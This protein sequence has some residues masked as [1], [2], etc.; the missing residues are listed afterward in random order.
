MD[1]RMFSK[2]TNEHISNV[3]NILKHFSRQLI[4]R[5]VEHDTSKFSDT[6]AELFVEYTPKLKASTYGSDEY[7]EFLKGLKP[8]LDRHYMVNRHHPEH[9]RNGI[10]GMN[11]VDVMEMLCDWKAA[12]LRHDDGDLMTSIKLNQ[13]KFGYSDELKSIF[14]ET[15]KLLYIYRIQWGCCDGRSGEYFSDTLDGIR[16]KIDEDLSLSDTERGIL[17]FGYFRDKIEDIT[18]DE[19]VIDNG[20]GIQWY[21]QDYGLIYH[22]RKKT[23]FKND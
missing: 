21:V 9:F 17:K 11:L 22:Y 18:T 4:R 16:A 10:A 2:E 15:A 5:G 6:E 12:T 23:L 13:S 7:K 3:Y 1:Y 20:F 8:A 14:V 19:I